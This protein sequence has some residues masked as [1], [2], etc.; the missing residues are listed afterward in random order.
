MA[1]GSGARTCEVIAEE[2]AQAT[3]EMAVVTPVLLVMALIVYNLMV[4]A[5]A[6]ARFDRIAPDI[7]LAHGV[8]P[9]GDDHAGTGE[10]A[11]SIQAEIAEVMGDYDV[12]VEVSVERGSEQT[13]SLLSLVGAMRSYRCEMRYRPWP[14]NWS[15]A[16]VSLG[17]PLELTH[18]RDVAVD[19]W[20]S[21]VVV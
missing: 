19:P 20:R 13:E 2:R 11:A 9:S 4:F 16:G 1:V 10:T 17:A 21:G 18:V 15:I 6:T 7:V 3:V 5:S 8:A 12:E 14:S